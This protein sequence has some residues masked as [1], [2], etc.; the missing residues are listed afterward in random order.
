MW[1]VIMHHNECDKCGYKLPVNSNYCNNCGSKIKHD[2]ETP[3]N[4][5]KQETSRRKLPIKKLII[6]TFVII[7]LMIGI[8]FWQYNIASRVKGL[9]YAE[10]YY[11]ASE[12]VDGIFIIL[13]PE[14]EAI[15]EK[16]QVLRS[17]ARSLELAMEFRYDTYDLSKQFYISRLFDVLESCIGYS[18]KAE[19]RNCKDELYSLQERAKNMIIDEGYIDTDIRSRLLELLDNDKYS[20]FPLRVEDE[21]KVKQL[22]DE[23]ANSISQSDIERVKNER[24]PLRFEKTELTSKGDYTYFYGTVKNYGS[25]TYR[26][27]KVRAVYKDINQNVLTTDS[28]Y[29]VG[30]EGIR[31][32]ESVQFEIMT[33]VRGDVE[34]GTIEI[35]D[36]DI[37]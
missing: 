8:V 29:A 36:Y 3:L 19:E 21:D 27:V 25:K 23:I 28:G 22:I 18:K 9:Y 1:G 17:P 5:I 12:K 20:F 26:F 13:D 15:K 2:D 31:P 34:Y 24:N 6:F 33:K 30:A 7:F 11:L 14:V 37:D 4:S 10:E 32:G 35:Y 16:L